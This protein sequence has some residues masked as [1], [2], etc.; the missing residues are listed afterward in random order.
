MLLASASL[1]GLGLSQ[2]M[3]AVQD[4]PNGSTNSSAIVLT[5]NSTQLQVLTGSAT[6]SGVI[7]Q[8][9]GTWGLSKIGS[10]TLVLAGNNTYGGGTMINAGTVVV[11]TTAFGT[12]FGTG[13]VTMAQGTTLGFSNSYT[14]ANNFALTGVLPPLKWSSLKYGFDQGGMDRWQGKGTRQK[15][16]S[17]SYGRSMC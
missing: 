5:D 7:S 2:A 9:G 13:A 17:R 14:V 12:A 16:L 10:G 8:T 3:G 6:Q 4:Y 1:L 15:R 11:G